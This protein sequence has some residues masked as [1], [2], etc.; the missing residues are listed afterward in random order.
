MNY[1]LDLPIGRGQLLSTAWAGKLGK[2]FEGWRLSGITTFESGNRFN[3][4]LPGDANNDGVRGDRPDRIGSG[5][6][7]S[8]QR[9][10]DHWFDTAAFLAP[11]QQY[12]FG[13]CGRNV[14][15]TPGSR[16]WDISFVKR[17]RITDG[18]NSLELRVQLFNAFNHTN[19]S[20][21]N[22]TYGTS[23]FGKIFGAGR[24]REIEIALKYTF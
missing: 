22:S 11:A 24:A 21:P 2:L 3:P 13:N 10:I 7:D 19:F 20:S 14:L 8:S 15:L 16:N 4:R 17:T 1:I 9:S 5:L 12:G 23:V 18:G 6:L